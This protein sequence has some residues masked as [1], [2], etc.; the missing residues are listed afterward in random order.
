LALSRWS[1]DTED[2]KHPGTRSIVDRA[3]AGARPGA[4]ILMH[5]SGPDM[6]QTVAA[7]PAIIKGIQSR[8][9]RIAPIC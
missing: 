1:K 2:W 6:S 4:V 3:L 8:G 5:D 9:L 7:L